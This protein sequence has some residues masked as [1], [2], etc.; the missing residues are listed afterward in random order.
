M[1]ELT[2]EEVT[3]TLALIRAILSPKQSTTFKELVATAPDLD[4]QDLQQFIQYLGISAL[5]KLLGNVKKDIEFPAINAI[6]EQAKCPTK[7]D[8]E[9]TTC[10][11]KPHTVRRVW[12]LPEHIQQLE[13]QVA[14]FKA[15]P[16]NKDLY[17]ETPEVDPDTRP[18]FTCTPRT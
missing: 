11:L 5:T 8:M 13:D 14:E 6:W 2:K 17:M 18:A 7:F 16:K 9:G 1:E 15:L 10:I 3:K 4:Q 12:K